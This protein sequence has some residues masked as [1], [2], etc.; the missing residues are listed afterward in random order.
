VLLL[1]VQVIWD[2]CYVPGQVVHDVSEGHIAF[3]VWV[4][5]LDPE[6]SSTTVLYETAGT[7][8]PRSQHHVPVNVCCHVFHCYRQT[9][10]LSNVC[11]NTRGE[12]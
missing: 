10:G 6:G 3:I 9:H 5:V 2:I 7:T 8:C 11:R 4:K 1:K 12:R